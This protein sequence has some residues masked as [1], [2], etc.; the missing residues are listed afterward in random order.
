VRAKRKQLQLELAESLKRNA[1]LEVELTQTK[2]ILHRTSAELNRTK[3]ELND[4]KKRLEKLGETWAQ[5]TKLMNSAAPLLPASKSI[6]SHTFNHE[7]NPLAQGP[8]IEENLALR[9]NLRDAEDEN[10]RLKE[11]CATQQ[12]QLDSLFEV[13]TRLSNEQKDFQQQLQGFME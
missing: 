6:A 3:V 1:N 9:E 4:A 2:E 12:S 13:T 10:D 11:L 7:N 5:A 8:W